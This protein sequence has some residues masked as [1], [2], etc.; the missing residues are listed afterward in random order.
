M[1]FYLTAFSE[2]MRTTV[3]IAVLV[4]LGSG[5]WGFALYFIGSSLGRFGAL[6]VGAYVQALRNIP[7]LLPIYLIYFG[8]P[9][10]G[11]A[12]TAAVC[13]GV[14]LILQQGAYIREILRGSAKA[15]DRNLYDAARSIGLSKWKT[16][17]LVTMPQVF[18]NALPALGSQCVLLFKDTSLLSA[19]SV[20]EI[21]MQSKILVEN[22]GT[23]YMPFLFAG[24]F[25]LLVAALIDISFRFLSTT[26]RWR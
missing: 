17:R 16:F 8:F 25:Y 3:V 21:M 11:L 5:L 24:G 9:M 10:I 26:V 7:V 2:A 12:W 15:I 20:V 14:A 18:A 22:S 1:T 19:I 23:I 6:A 13:G 4:A